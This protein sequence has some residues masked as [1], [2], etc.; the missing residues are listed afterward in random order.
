MKTFSLKNWRE[1]EPLINE[2][3]QKYGSHKIKDFKLSNQILFRGQADSG[4]PLKTTLER[5]SDKTWTV[6]SYCNAVIDCSPEILSFTDGTWQLPHRNELKEELDDTFHARRP[7]IPLYEYIVY[8]RQ[9]SFPSPLLD[10]TSSPY[11]ALFFALADKTNNENG[12]VFVYI[13]TPQG[14]KSTTGGSP[15][16]DVQGPYIK[17]HKR[18]FLQKAW[19]TIATNANPETKDHQFLRHDQVFENQ[20][21][22]VVEQDV[23]LKIVIPT[24]LRME[25]LDYLDYYNINYFSL[26]QTE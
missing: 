17:T 25:I 24:E 9:H 4:W 21:A 15:Q 7:Y 22:S 12:T 26:F 19:Y 2:I 18:H 6:R 10:W 14:V 20:V 11:I 5:A 3:R 8:L 23:I 1:F 16:I 13:E